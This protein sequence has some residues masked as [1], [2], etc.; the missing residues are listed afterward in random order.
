MEQNARIYVAGHTGLIGSAM[1]RKLRSFGYSNILTKTHK[2]MDLI[3]NEK[4]KEFFEKENPQYVFLAAAKVGG[5]YANNTYPADFVYEN[6]MIQTNV[7]DLSYRYGVKKLLFLVS[8][9]VYPKMCQQP[10]KEEYLMTGPLEPTNEP[11]GIAKL[12]GMKM[13]QAYNRQ[14]GTNFISAIPANVYGIN[15][16]FDE[17]GHVVAS[18]IKKF[19]E[20]KVKGEEYVTIWG[21]GRPKREFLYADDLAK[22]CIFLM[23]HYQENEPINVGTGVGTSVSELAELMKDVAEFKGSI[24]YD[25]TK[26]DGNPVRLL[27]IEK[28]KALGWSAK[29]PLEEGLRATYQWYQMNL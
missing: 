3:Q 13:C 16:H 14:Y 8:S 2:E 23:D 7:I 6:L 22:A 25:H 21:T 28:I 18:L 4:V 10:M 12:A 29:V 26:P 11:F 27:D 1:V 15:D 24:H 9:C 19:H 20:A 17:E 5:I